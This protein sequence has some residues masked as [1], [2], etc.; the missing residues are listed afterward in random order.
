MSDS[1]SIYKARVDAA[2]MMIHEH[3]NEKLV[4]EDLAKSAGFSAFHFHRLFSAM[5]GETPQQFLTRVRLE[6]AANM[7]VKYSGYSITQIALNCGFSSPSVFARSF[8]NHFGISANEYRKVENRPV[9]PDVHPNEAYLKTRSRRFT[10]ISS[11]SP[12]ASG[13]K[14]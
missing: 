2:I 6:R 7:L 11:P 12:R 13:W 8:K 5:V 1:R 14:A 10:P 3:L 9:P 4:L